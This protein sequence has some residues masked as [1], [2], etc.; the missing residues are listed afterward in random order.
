MVLLWSVT[1][2]G[3]GRLYWN[4]GVRRPSLPAAILVLHVPPERAVVLVLFASVR[5]SYVAYVPVVGTLFLALPVAVH[6]I[7]RATQAKVLNIQESKGETG[8]R[9]TAVMAQEKLHKLLAER[10]NKGK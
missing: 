8:G 9:K 5:V 1:V 7:A 4:Y 6:T 10:C 3:G 2:G